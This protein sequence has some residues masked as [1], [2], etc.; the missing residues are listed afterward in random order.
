LI[1]FHLVSVNDRRSAESGLTIVLNQVRL[2][3][4]LAG[5]SGWIACLTEEK[6]HIQNPATVPTFAQIRAE[7][8]WEGPLPRLDANGEEPFWARVP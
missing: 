4:R 1:G 6:H 5:C 8:D 2:P 7:L 3:A